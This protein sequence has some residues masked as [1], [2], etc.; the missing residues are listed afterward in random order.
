MAYRQI[1]NR[2]L[3]RLREDVLS[4]NW[5]GAVIDASSDQVDAYQKLM[6][7]QMMQLYSKC[8][9]NYIIGINI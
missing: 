6:M 8:L 3:I 2:V 4:S 9:M 1:I 7:I 5:T